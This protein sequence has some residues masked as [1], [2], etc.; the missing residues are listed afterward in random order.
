MNSNDNLARINSFAKKWK[1]KFLDESTTCYELVD[2][3]F[4][5]ECFELGFDMDS[6]HSFKEKYG[7]GAFRD[8]NALKKVVD[9]IFDIDLLGSALHSAWRYYNHWAYSASE[10][11]DNRE[12]FILIFDRLI[13]LTK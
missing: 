11:D 1:E 7:S 2:I 8:S 6:G 10:I 12:W 13:Q 9:K 4:G 3:K 5:E